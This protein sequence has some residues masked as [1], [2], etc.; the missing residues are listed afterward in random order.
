MA[1][2]LV[3]QPLLDDAM[4]EF[5]DGAVDITVRED[6]APLSGSELRSQARDYDGLVTLLTDR[7]DADFLEANPHLQVVSNVAV[8]YDN[9]DVSAASAHGVVVTNTPGV[10]TETTADLT[11]ALLLAAARRVPEADA[12]MR[13]GRYER[14]V[15]AQEHLGVDVFGQT[16]GIVGMG[17]I[18]QAVARRAAHG[19]A[20]DVCYY[21]PRPLQAERNAEL[22]IRPV[23]L[24]ELLETSDFVS[25][26]APLNKQTYH[27]V[28]AAALERMK[29]SA[30]LVN[31][32]RGPL[33]DEQALVDALRRGEIRGAGLDV[34]EAEPAMAPGLADLR[35][36]VVLLPHLGSATR[37]T[38]REMCRMA[39]GDAVAVLS[40]AQPQH[41]VAPR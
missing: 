3:T 22:G 11:W 7:V 28:D 31:P 6:P 25:L 5:R 13:A 18:G 17:Q 26:H 41:A 30:I 32:G 21:D 19:F 24:D 38:R 9:I 20:M 39:L 15:I 36:S 8:G 40:G 27:L 29:P 34:Y 16:L 2:L 14:W 35:E 4:K 10:L 33:V 12:Y 37:R 23:P 1:R